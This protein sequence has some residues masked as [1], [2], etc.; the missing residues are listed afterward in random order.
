MIRTWISQVDIAESANT[1]NSR[2]QPLR[3]IS[4]TIIPMSI[5]LIGLSTY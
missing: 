1:L 4:K 2:N 5:L 3:N